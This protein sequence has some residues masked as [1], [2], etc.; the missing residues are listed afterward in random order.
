MGIYPSRW[1]C[2]PALS[3]NGFGLQIRFF[4]YAGLQIRRDKRDKLCVFASLRSVFIATDYNNI[5]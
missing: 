1:I 3:A 2:N 4:Y 5:G